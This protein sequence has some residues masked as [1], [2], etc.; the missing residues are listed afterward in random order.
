MV[1]SEP[2][3]NPSGESQTPLNEAQGRRE[4]CGE[5]RTGVPGFGASFHRSAASGAGQQHRVL[6]RACVVDSERWESCTH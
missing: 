1:T 3:R 5:S 4:R 6:E 2:D